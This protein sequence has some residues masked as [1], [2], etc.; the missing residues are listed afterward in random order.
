MAILVIAEL[1]GGDAALE[2][3]MT[4]ELGLQD[5]PAPGSIARF[6][7]P[8]DNG[9]RVI[10]VWESEEAFQIF[11]RE[12]LM[13]AFERMRISPPKTQVFPLESVRIAPPA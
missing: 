3:R 10:T 4:E 5:D 13:S 11:A 12:R 2:A 9:W 1:Q 8:V 6:A 7:G